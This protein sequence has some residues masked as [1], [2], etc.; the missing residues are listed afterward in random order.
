[1]RKAIALAAAAAAVALL[2]L[3][4]SAAS[5]EHPRVKPGN[6]HALASKL[7]ASNVWYAR[8][9]G[10]FVDINDVHQWARVSPCFS[11][12]TAC[13]NWLYWEMTD[14]PRDQDVQRCR[15]G[16]AGVPMLD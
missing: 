11:S 8:F 5:T 4:G 3:A 9:S 10:F 13:V 16:I 6:C 15:K 12:Q 2:A 7:G 14:Y 1:M